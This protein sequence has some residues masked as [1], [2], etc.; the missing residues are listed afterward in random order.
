[1][2][3]WI[4]PRCDSVNAPQNVV[5]A[6]CSPAL[7]PLSPPQHAPQLPQPWTLA[8]QSAPLADVV[9]L[10]VQEPNPSPR[11]RRQK[12]VYDDPRFNEFYNNYPLHR[13]RWA[14][15]SAWKEV[16][17]AGIAPQLIIESAAKY[18]ALCDRNSTPKDKIKYPAGWLRA[19]RWEDEYP[20]LEVNTP[21][22][23]DWEAARAEEDARIAALLEEGA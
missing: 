17:A 19:G 5:C 18:A 9:D 11:K 20:D 10:E 13:E 15:F 2:S 16:I 4:C 8:A 23:T 1:M 14:A 22:E 6:A 12:Y 3:P 21:R 7:A